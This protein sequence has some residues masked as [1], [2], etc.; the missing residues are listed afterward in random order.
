MT[1]DSTLMHTNIAEAH[2]IMM[3]ET[4]SEAEAANILRI[5]VP[6]LRRLRASKRIAFLRLSPRKIF[7]LGQNLV[8]FLVQSTEV[9]QCP[10]TIRAASTRSETSGSPVSRPAQPGIEHGMTPPADKH[11]ALASAHGS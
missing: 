9:A 11:A 10:D 1:A 8:E 5:S 7:Y 6:T 2:G 4:Y 3:G